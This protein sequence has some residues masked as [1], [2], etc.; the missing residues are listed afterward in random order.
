MKKD[1]DSI[2]FNTAELT[3]GALTVTSSSFNEPY[4]QP[5]SALTIDKATERATLKLPT[6]LVEGS[7]VQ[8]RVGFEADL[9][10]ALMGYYRSA[11]QKDGKTKYYSLTQFEVRP[12]FYIVSRSY[13]T[14]RILAY[15][16]PPCI[17]LLG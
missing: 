16:C 17:S 10:G 4:V 1:T 13:S 14:L 8:F 5:A 7:T 12:P 3:L 15:C 2:T 6:T 11:F 9:T